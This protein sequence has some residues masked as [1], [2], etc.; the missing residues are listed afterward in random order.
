MRPIAAQIWSGSLDPDLDDSPKLS[1]DAVS[2]RES[3]PLEI[4]SE[5]LPKESASAKSKTGGG[6]GK[7]TSNMNQPPRI[8]PE[9][10]AE[11]SFRLRQVGSNWTA[12]TWYS[13]GMAMFHCQVP[14]HV[15]ASQCTS[16]NRSP[17][18]CLRAT[19]GHDGARRML[20]RWPG[21]ERGRIQV[22]GLAAP[23]CAAQT[24]CCLF[25]SLTGALQAPQEK[26]SQRQLDM[27]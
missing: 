2:S 11:S 26:R 22:V 8:C 12:Y 13:K 19:M 10:R 9:L 14:A 24:G 18:N 16:G 23:L 7:A 20:T 17:S 4:V 3:V 27:A 1:V 25:K 6:G 5:R 21:G 15:N